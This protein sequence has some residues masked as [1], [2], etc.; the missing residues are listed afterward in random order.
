MLCDNEDDGMNIKYSVLLT[1]LQIAM[2][3]ESKLHNFFYK[4]SDQATI[5]SCLVSY[6]HM[7]NNFSYNLTKVFWR[8]KYIS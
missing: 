1:G 6:S 8:E 4:R 7:A 2:E 3:A 5:V